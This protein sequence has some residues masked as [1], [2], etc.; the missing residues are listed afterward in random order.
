[1]EELIMNHANET[2]A[3]QSARPNVALDSGS[4][5][6]YQYVG[7][8]VR[9]VASVLDSIF[10]LIIIWPL[11]YWVYGADMFSS[12]EMVKGSADVLLSYIFPMVF[13]IVLWMKFGGTPAKRILKIKVLDE[14]TGQHLSLAKSL[15]RYVGYFVSILGL[16]IGFI[17]VAFDEKK[18]GWHD[19]IAGSI[20][21]IG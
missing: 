6:Q 16:F 14:S 17:W 10:L 1:M 13:S 5:M 20:V 15:L 7:F 2:Q 11:L 19:H 3:N 12:T 18:K 8:W 4:A 21:V 9:A